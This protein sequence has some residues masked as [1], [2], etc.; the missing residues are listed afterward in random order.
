MGAIGRAVISI[1]P[2]AIRGPFE[3]LLGIHSPSR[4]FA[5]Y[6]VNIG[7]GLINGL[8][9]MHSS[10]ASSVEGLVTVPSV[11]SFGSGSYTSALGISGGG[12]SPAIYVQNPFTGEYLLA[13]V[14]GRVGA[15]MD[16]VAS[17][18]AGRSR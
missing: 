14:D 12:S 11:P 7:Q 2:E 18:K 4:V 8:D 3:Q 10:I 16:H 6:G 1:V 17:I 13:Q 15:G 5:G 9:G